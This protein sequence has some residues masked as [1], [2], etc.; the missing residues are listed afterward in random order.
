MQVSYRFNHKFWYC[1]G[2]AEGQPHAWLTPKLLCG[3]PNEV[4]CIDPIWPWHAPRKY[5]SLY[6]VYERDSI[7]YYGIL[8]DGVKVGNFLKNRNKTKPTSTS[9]LK[10]IDE[11]DIN[12]FVECP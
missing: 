7:S 2:L 11:I 1:E 6:P 8:M 10:Y 3:E 9:I 5:H 12:S 4:W